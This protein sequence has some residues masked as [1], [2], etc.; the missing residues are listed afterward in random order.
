MYLCDVLNYL[1]NPS[2][3]LTKTERTAMSSY[4]HFSSSTP[5]PPSSSNSWFK[6][7]IALKRIFWA[8]AIAGSGFLGYGNKKFQKDF[9]FVH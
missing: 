2:N 5:P 4:R 6:R 1:S 3:H 9:K 8:T 7:R